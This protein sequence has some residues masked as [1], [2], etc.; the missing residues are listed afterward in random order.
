MAACSVCVW[1][2]VRSA[3]LTN[4]SSDI[5]NVIIIVTNALSLVGIDSGTRR[6]DSARVALSDV[7]FCANALVSVPSFSVGTLRLT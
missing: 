3:V 1:R 7:I 5:E 6:T 4:K 2:R